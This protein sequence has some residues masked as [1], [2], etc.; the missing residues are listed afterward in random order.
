MVSTMNT[1]TSPDEILEKARLDEAYPHV[2]PASDFSLSTVLGFI[3]E[4]E[5]SYGAIQ[6][7]LQETELDYYQQTG[8]HILFEDA[9]NKSQQRNVFKRWLDKIV[10]WFKKVVDKFVSIWKA[11]F[12]RFNSVEKQNEKII[13]QYDDAVD[14]AGGTSDTPVEAPS[15]PADTPTPVSIPGPPAAEV[16]FEGYNFVNLENFELKPW[17]IHNEFDVR[18]EEI[19][20]GYVNY[21]KRRIIERIIPQ[22]KDAQDKVITD[23]AKSLEFWFHG[24]KQKRIYTVAQAKEH[25]KAFKQSNQNQLKNSFNGTRR[26]LDKYQKDFADAKAKI[27]DPNSNIARRY[28]MYS[29]VAKFNAEVLQ[30]VIN[31]YIQALIDRNNQAQQIIIAATGAGNKNESTVSSSKPRLVLRESS[32]ESIAYRMR[33][34]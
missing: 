18:D 23:F 17:S 34:S 7:A 31:T 2:Q 24:T 5:Q 19:Q 26:I 3:A 14:K 33:N 10:E 15:S 30:I 28:T 1:Y 12:G 13:K 16:E 4:A 9:E 27:T 25:L 22:F 32:I 8:G 20:D 6:L 11:I 21:A 29:E